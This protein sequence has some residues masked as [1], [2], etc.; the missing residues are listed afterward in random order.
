MAEKFEFD[1]NKV[2]Y[3]DVKNLDMDNEEQVREF[4]AK[5]IARW[6]Y[7]ESPSKDS[8]DNMGLQD[9]AELQV[10]FTERL[11]SMFRPVPATE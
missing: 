3:K 10:T 5:V 7:D 6:P 2:T 1:F 4:I 8:I 11:E 9:F